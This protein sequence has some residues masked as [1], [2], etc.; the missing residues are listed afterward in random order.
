[1]GGR[2][3]GLRPGELADLVRFRLADGC[4]VVLETYLGGER[5]FAASA[6]G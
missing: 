2:Q 4:L 6:M 1:V 3:R 5:V